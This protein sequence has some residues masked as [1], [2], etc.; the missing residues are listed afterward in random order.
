[1]CTTLHIGFVKKGFAIISPQNVTS[2]RTAVQ[3][4][5]RQFD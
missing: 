1:M 2:P 4:M 3:Q 5:C